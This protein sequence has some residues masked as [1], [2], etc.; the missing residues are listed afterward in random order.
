MLM[1]GQQMACERNSMAATSKE[2]RLTNWK[3]LWYKTMTLV[4]KGSNTL[5]TPQAHHPLYQ[6]Q[7]FPGSPLSNSHLSNSKRNV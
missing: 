4:R 1:F 6:Q 2:K 7:S 3:E 5:H